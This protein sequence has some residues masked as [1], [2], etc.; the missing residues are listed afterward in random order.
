MLEFYKKLWLSGAV[1]PARGS[2]DLIVC[3]KMNILFILGNFYQIIFSI[4]CSAGLPDVGVLQ[5]A[6]AVR[7]CDSSQMFGGV[8]ENS[9]NEDPW[10]TR[11][12]VGDKTGFSV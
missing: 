1:T 3:L 6:V 4:N 9:N 12:I 5:E 8:Q 7:S 2:D 10:T 11:T